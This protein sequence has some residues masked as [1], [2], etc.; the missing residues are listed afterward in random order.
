MLYTS[1]PVM[2]NKKKA[3]SLQIRAKMSNLVKTIKH[4]SQG[5]KIKLKSKNNSKRREFKASK[6]TLPKL[7]RVSLVAK[8]RENYTSSINYTYKIRRKLRK[9]VNK[10]KVSS[11][12]QK[13]LN[14]QNILNTHSN[15]NS[16]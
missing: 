12:S 16:D 6:T 14:R 3:K 2:R 4:V 10:S 5:L 15:Q 13:T 8:I 1:L 7:K 9:E 11:H